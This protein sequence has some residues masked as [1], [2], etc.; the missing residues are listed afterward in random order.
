MIKPNLPGPL[1]ASLLVMTFLS[2]FQFACSG[3]LAATDPLAQDTVEE[4]RKHRD[5]AKHHDLSHGPDLST[6][7][8]MGIGHDMSGGPVPDPPPASCDQRHAG[9]TGIQVVVR[10]DEYHG[11][12]HGKNGDHEIVYGTVT[13]T[14]WVFDN[15]IV[16]TGNVELAMNVHSAK[17]P[18]GLPNEIPVTPG[19]SL[20][21]EGEYIPASTANAH[22]KNGS[23]AVI[24]YTH[25]PCGFVNIGG[26]KYR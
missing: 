10:V 23:A 12:I 1:H 2:S 26:M 4:D 22:D 16:D 19:D 20:E 18:S 11:L 6:G 8:D 14:V 7:H 24:H 3:E 9:V 13:D 17:D 15:T 21:I 25:T 5:M